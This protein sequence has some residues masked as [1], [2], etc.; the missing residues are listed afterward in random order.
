MD[1]KKY[2]TFMVPNPDELQ[3]LSELYK[4]MGDYTRM[5]ILWH[6]M[7]KD[8]CVSELAEK[9]QTT[10]SAVSPPAPCAADDPAGLLLQVRQKVIYSLQDEHIGW[11]LEE[12]YTH[13]S[14]R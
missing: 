2:T 7:E 5:R 6:L 11:I 9:L 12:T 14:E 1:I 13:I 4:A 3:Q 8:C 10:K